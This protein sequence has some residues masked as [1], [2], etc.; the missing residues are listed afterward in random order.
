MWARQIGET[1]D[2]STGTDF[3][4]FYFIFYIIVC[5][6]FILNLFMGVVISSY[7]RE[8]E[9]LENNHMLTSTQK[10]WLETKKLI[11]ETKLKNYMKRPKQ[12]W[13]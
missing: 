4:A 5:S 13:R 11:V 6:F 2:Q 12:A 3:L 10:K 8:K 7:N 9:N 1:K